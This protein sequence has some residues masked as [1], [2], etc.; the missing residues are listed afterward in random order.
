MRNIN[1]YHNL[2]K[3]EINPPDWIF[4]PVWTILYC[5]IFLS[6]FVFLSKGN[7]QQKTEPLTIFTIQLILNFIWSP[8]FFGMKKIGFALIINILL[9]ISIILL[10]ISFWHF[11]KIAGI[12]LIPYFIWASFALYLNFMIW[13][14]N[15]TQK[16]I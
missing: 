6:L 1:W 4:A 5:M 12:L 9:W 13:K 3:P 11:S 10:I 15:Q 8:V 16:L 2:N 14:L 7:I